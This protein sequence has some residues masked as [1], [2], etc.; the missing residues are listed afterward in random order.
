V[1]ETSIS[2][3]V[4]EISPVKKKLSFGVPWIDVK[5]ELDAV[6]QEVNK[7][8][9]IRGFRQGKI[10]RNILETYYKE[11]AEN[12]AASNLI[13]RFYWEA[14]KKSELI[15]LTQPMIEQ[16]GIEADKDFIFSAIIETESNFEPQNYTGL[17]LEKEEY[18]VT[19]EDIDARLQNMREM[20]ATMEEVAEDKVV[21]EGNYVNINF[22]GVLDGHALKELKA[23]NYFLE[24]GSKTFIPGFEEQI[25]GMKKNATK[26][27]TIKF[28]E[29]YHVERLKN[30]TV[31]FSLVL[32]NIREKKLPEINE[33]FI[34]NFDKYENLEELK[35]D[36]Q[37]FIE[38]DNAVKSDVALREK[39]IDNLLEN[40][41]FEVPPSLVELQ[42]RYMMTEAQ[43]RMV[44]SG[45]EQNKA[46]EM[47]FKLH[48]GFK[49]EAVKIVKTALILKSIAKKERIEVTEQEIDAKI[50][51]IAEKNVQDFDTFKKSLKQNG[52]LENVRTELLHKKVFDL[53]KEKSNVKNIK[54]SDK[55][56]GEADNK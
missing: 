4:E 37:K 28:P 16:N 14:V 34:K 43:R 52:L 41:V 50:E 21:E 26:T 18:D 1:T 31:E 13:N 47:S 36:I 6:Y 20:F 49:D 32:N 12:E 55:N 7:K 5:K 23:E 24:V 33:N 44:A 39:I 29:D 30:K 9:K 51:E 45:I 40:N 22:Q 17:E 48:D 46:T 8:V 25:I 19:E 56:R 10:P 38:E 11:H 35:K 54:Q 27:F 3:K 2:L 42:I 15:P 53:I